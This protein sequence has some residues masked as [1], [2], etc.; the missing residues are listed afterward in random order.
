MEFDAQFSA[1]DQLIAIHD[2][3]LD[4]TTTG[5]GRVTDFTAAQL[6]EFD[7]SK[8]YDGWGFEPDRKSVV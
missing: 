6:R 8:G 1:D 2:D 4:R 7:A 3:T 5:T